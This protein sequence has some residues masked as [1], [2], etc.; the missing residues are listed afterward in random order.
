MVAVESQSL[1]DEINSN[2][3]PRFQAG[4]RDMNAVM[5]SSFVMGKALLEESRLKNLAAFEAKLKLTMLPLAQDRWKTHLA[6]N[7]EVINSYVNVMKHYFSVKHDMV[8]LN[9]DYKIKQAVWPLTI[10]DFERANLGAMQGAVNSDTSGG[11]AS[12][13]AKVLGGVMSGAAAGAMVGGVPGAIVGGV[14]GGV[15]GLL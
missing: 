12:K 11:G 8:S 5:S 4:M 15:A 1:S 13:G 2:V 6:W 10:M 9:Y 14:L 3:L 7:Q